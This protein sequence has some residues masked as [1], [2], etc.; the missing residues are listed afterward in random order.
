MAGLFFLFASAPLPFLEL[1]SQ[2][3]T[4]I[5]IYLSYAA[6]IKTSSQTLAFS[7]WITWFLGKVIRS[8]D[9]CTK[10]KFYKKQ[11]LCQENDNHLSFR[12]AIEVLIKALYQIEP[13]NFICEGLLFDYR[14][15]F[16]L[17]SICKES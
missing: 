17:N 6:I 15:L 12:Y 4:R 11:L 5:V 9:T 13:G 7:Y 16:A 8:R 2:V 3:I 10:T 1:L 14:Y